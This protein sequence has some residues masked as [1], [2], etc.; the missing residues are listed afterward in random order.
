M[1]RIL[2]T[3]YLIATGGLA[4]IAMA[5]PIVVL[6]G[7]FLIIPGLILIFAPTAFLWGCIYAAAFSVMQLMLRPKWAGLAA[8][9]LTA[10]ALWQI[11]Q[12]STLRANE[13]LLRYQ[14]ADVTPRAPIQ[15]YGD[16]RVDTRSPDWD[17][18]NP[19]K[20]V[21]RAYACDNRC[22]A[23]LFEPGVR[24]VTVTRADAPSFDDIRDGRT[25]IDQSART[26][27]LLPQARCGDRA[28]NPT[29]SS[30]T[31]VFDGS[32]ED[33]QATAAEWRRRLT[34]D[35]CLVRDAPI[36]RFDLLIRSGE[37]RLDKIGVPS[38]S[39]W[40]RPAP[41][42]RAGYS[43]IRGSGG[44]I[45]F[46]RFRL[47]VRAL[48][49]PFSIGPVSPLDSLR[50]GWSTQLLPPGTSTDWQ[51]LVGEADA[52]L[53]VGHERAPASARGTP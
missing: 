30:R 41:E 13:A 35:V 51:D 42:P 6:I 12:P 21:E 2:L 40:A 3:V 22:L 1:M 23:L 32:P 28:L 36:D 43:E 4:F 37:W 11:P 48:S 18:S 29:L 34:S 17:D 45:L 33:K 27:R 9:L 24:S 50:F 46:R 25:R 38:R 39:P 5:F 7:M 52:A 49:V 44:K 20:T 10:L 16:I 26:Y 8:V 15:P 47:A 31:G 53:A 19:E 14:L